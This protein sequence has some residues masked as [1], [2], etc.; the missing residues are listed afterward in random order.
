MLHYSCLISLSEV[1]CTKYKDQKFSIRP[2]AFTLC[3]EYAA[4]YRRGILC[5]HHV[6]GRGMAICARQSCICVGSI[7]K[8]RMRG[9]RTHLCR[10]L[11]ILGLRA[12]I[13]KWSRTNRVTGWPQ[14]KKNPHMIPNPANKKTLRAR[15]FCVW[16]RG[17]DRRFQTRGTGSY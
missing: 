12:Q 1:P 16:H 15:L 9:Y 2:T 14:T 5:W 13:Q 7:L 4:N 17:N 6:I 11:V 8:F 3:L 10:I